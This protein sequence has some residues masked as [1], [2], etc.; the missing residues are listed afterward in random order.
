M[1]RKPSIHAGLQDIAGPTTYAGVTSPEPVG[2][3][4]VVS[5][6]AIPL[7]LTP[8]MPFRSV[9]SKTRRNAFDVPPSVR[10]ID[11]RV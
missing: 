5:D 2:M 9:L 10:S 3:A 4:L 7:M 6:C 8:K 11:G 1:D